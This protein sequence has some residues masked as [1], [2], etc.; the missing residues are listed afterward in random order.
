MNAKKKKKKTERNAAKH[1]PVHPHGRLCSSSSD[2]HIFP[3]A[4]TLF[5][6]IFC[7]KTQRGDEM[8]KVNAALIKHFGRRKKKDSYVSLS[9]LEATPSPPSCRLLHFVKES[10]SHAPPLSLEVL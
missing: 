2:K 8:R 5:P 6:F 10:L 3:R 7:F 9:T 1:Q 4:P